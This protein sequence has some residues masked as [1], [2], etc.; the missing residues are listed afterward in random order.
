MPIAN[1]IADML[2]Q[3]PVADARRKTVPSER[4][5]FGAAL[6]SADARPARPESAD[7]QPAPSRHAARPDSS[8]QHGQAV[9]ETVSRGQRADEARD[10]A[11]AR[12]ASARDDKASSRQADRA[13]AAA[14]DTSNAAQASSQGERARPDDGRTGD[15]PGYGEKEAET[16]SAATPDQSPVVQVAP[17]ATITPASAALPG[18]DGAPQTALPVEPLPAGSDGVALEPGAQPSAAA[19]EGTAT[20]AANPVILPVSPLTVTEASPAQATSAT[21]APSAGPIASAP[22]TG[23]AAAFAT[24]SAAAGAAPQA[25]S[26]GEQTTTAATPA[27]ASFAATL[28]AATPADAKA[29]TPDQTLPMVAQTAAASSSPTQ[30]PVT[31]PQQAMARADAPV[32]LQAFAVEVG[33]RALRGAKE[34]QIRLDPEDLGRVDIRLEISEKGEVQAKVMVERVE[35]LQL[36]QRDAR[37]LERAFD[38]AG[39]KTNSDAL[40]FSLSDP[41]RGNRDERQTG[42]SD[43]QD[44]RGDRGERGGIAETPA[45]SAIYRAPSLGALD[46]SI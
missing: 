43:R 22:V 13:E 15:H 11:E 21:T 18:G 36:L 24:E 33:M 37:T 25:A 17:L 28:T 14:D 19:P 10:H 23:N 31:T 45:I 41:G 8:E 40:Q 27:A 20:G 30:A 39:L 6:S 7:R 2:P 1:A 3:R 38:Q 34:F 35:T 9:R 42:G 16:A 29:G 46:I 26:R 44:R 12:R 5:N 4:A 32:P